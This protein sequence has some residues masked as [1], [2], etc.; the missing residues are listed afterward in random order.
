MIKLVGGFMPMAMRL[1]NEK[2]EY[3]IWIAV[4]IIAATWSGYF[5]VQL[6][7]LPIVLSTRFLH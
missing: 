3:R 4:L 6:G 2:D 1:V 7:L 5:A